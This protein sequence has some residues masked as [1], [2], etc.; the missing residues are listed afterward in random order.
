MTFRYI[1][2]NF[3][4]PFTRF[5]SN[6]II[7]VGDRPRTAKA[8]GR[9]DEEKQSYEIT[10]ELP[11]VPK[12]AIEISTTNKILS[13]STKEDANNRIPQYYKEFYFRTK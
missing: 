13:I 1:R 10:I 11:A 9:Y 5:L 6:N 7:N 4:F 3:C 8:F 2:S 12:D